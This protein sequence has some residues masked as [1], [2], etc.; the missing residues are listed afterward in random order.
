M[1]LLLAE[2][3]HALSEAIVLILEHNNYS[4]DAVYDG[5]EALDY[6]LSEHYDGILLDIMMPKMDGLTV[7]KR[8][9]EQGIK[10]PV[11]MLTAKSEVR[12]RVEGLDLGADDYLPKP[13]AMAE[14]L[15]R[16]RALT[17]RSGEFVPNTLTMGDT[18]LDRDRFELRCGDKALRLSKK[19]YQMME[20]LMLNRG[21]LLSTEQFMSRIWGYD[22]D[23]EINVVWVYISYLRKKLSQLG[24]RLQIAAVRG[25]GYVLE[26][27]DDQGN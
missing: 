16:V 26:E 20:M 8:L 11:M 1:K 7:L 9:R 18:S 12:D 27:L 14:L 21:R 10:T 17:R 19:E 25:R 2:D 23:A 15:A 6:I 22:S 13:F 3:E 5:Q 24:S 4:V